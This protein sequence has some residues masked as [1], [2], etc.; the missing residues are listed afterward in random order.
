VAVDLIPGHPHLW[1][2]EAKPKGRALAGS[3]RRYTV[4]FWSV[5]QIRRNWIPACDSGVATFVAIMS[6]DEM[7]QRTGNGSE[8]PRD[9]HLKEFDTLRKEIEWML[10]DL[11]AAERN[12]VIAVGTFWAFLI[13]E[14]KEIEHLKYGRLAWSVPVM[15]ALLGFLRSLKLSINITLEGKYIGKIEEWIRTGEVGKAVPG[16]WQHFQNEE[17]ERRRKESDSWIVRLRRYLRFGLSTMDFS[18]VIFWGILILTTLTGAIFGWWRS[19]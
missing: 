2:C 10:Q 15:F 12:L 16:G 18:S 14:N 8:Y 7:P 3:V 6:E 17:N 13:T 9:F 4:C 5:F 11:R 1:Q 19:S